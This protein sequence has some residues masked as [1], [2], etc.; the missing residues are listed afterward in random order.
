M[1]RKKQ[2]MLTMQK[3]KTKKLKNKTKG[4]TISLD[5]C[6]DMETQKHGKAGKKKKR[7]KGGW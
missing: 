7:S 4:E 6:M 3:S 1:E 2:N 5:V